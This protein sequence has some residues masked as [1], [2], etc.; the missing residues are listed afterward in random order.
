MS[1]KASPLVNF[2]RFG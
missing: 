2:Y 1:I